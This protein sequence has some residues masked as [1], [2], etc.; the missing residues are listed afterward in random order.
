MAGS[1]GPLLPSQTSYI[2]YSKGVDLAL[3]KAL[4]RTSY[5]HKVCLK[6][7]FSLLPCPLV[8]VGF[9]PAISRG[10]PV[11]SRMPAGGGGQ[12]TIARHADPP[13]AELLRRLVPSNRLPAFKCRLARREVY[14]A[15]G[16]PIQVRHSRL[17]PGT[18]V[19]ML[20]LTECSAF[21]QSRARPNQ[22]LRPGQKGLRSYFFI[23]LTMYRAPL[24]IQC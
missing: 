21:A 4:T 9:F 10:F 1:T 14:S 2:L 19:R 16:I 3:V 8:L 13:T 7:T 11:F 23:V 20:A 18:S 5:V 15:S 12:K 24:R 22:S 6:N 17:P